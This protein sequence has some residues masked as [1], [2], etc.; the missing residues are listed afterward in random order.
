MRIAV[1]SDVHGNAAALDACLGQLERLAVDERVFIGD[2][3][4]Y[5]PAAA[6][7]VA[8]L[9]S[10]G[11]ACQQGNH[12]AM[13]LEPDGV[14]AE[15]EA[16]YRLSGARAQFSGEQ[17]A[18]IAAW[19]RSRTAVCDGRHVLFVHGAPS[20]PL[21]GYVYPDADL[22]GWDALPHDAVFMGHTHR[23]FA[24]RQGDVLIVNAGS[25]GL[26]RDVGGLASFAVYDTESDTVRHYRVAFDAE[27]VLRRAGEAVHAA[28]RDCLRRRADR[29]VGELI[30]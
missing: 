22:T 26:P 19:P 24:A 11:F 29:F 27:A 14:S 20:D 5:L 8:R 25:V 13:L 16:V 2:A 28:T 12:E 7:C 15:R 9:Q 17:Q 6:E 18:A 23:P 4:G 30:G 10:E 3:V 21:E 1:L